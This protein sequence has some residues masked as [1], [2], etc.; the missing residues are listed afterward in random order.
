[1]PKFQFSK[2]VRDKIISQQL[3]SGAKPHYRKLSDKDHINALLDKIVEETKEITHAKSEEIASEIADVQ[4]AID[5]LVEKYGLTRAD[6]DQA[7]KTKTA[8]NGSFKKGIF[9]D[10]VEVNENDKWVDYYRNNPDRY[11]EVD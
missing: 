3:E 6:I 1:M 9:V 8:K 2:L 4:Q 10:W 7:Q 11:P 5:D